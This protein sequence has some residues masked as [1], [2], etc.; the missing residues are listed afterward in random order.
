MEKIRQLLRNSL[1]NDAGASSIRTMIGERAYP[2]ELA[3]IANPTLP[4]INFDATGESF[5]AV[6]EAWHGNVRVWS[7]SG[8]KGGTK[9]DAWKL[10]DL[11][12]LHWHQ[13]AFNDDTLA[14]YVHLMQSGAPSDIFD[15]TLRAYAV[16]SDFQLIGAKTT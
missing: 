5:Q 16:V 15:D 13:G 7:W 8:K 10:H 14:R 11:L 2:D 1:V 4:C 9:S 3:S 6:T 12:V